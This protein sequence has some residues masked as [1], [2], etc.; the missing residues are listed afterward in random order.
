MSEVPTRDPST[1]K[2][3]NIL[4]IPVLTRENHSPFEMIFPL[5]DDKGFS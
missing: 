4:F 3:I 1:A 2:A 5:G